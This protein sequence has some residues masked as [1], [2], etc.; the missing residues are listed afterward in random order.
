MPRGRRPYL[1]PNIEFKAKL[2]GPLVEA[3]DKKLVTLSASW[4]DPSRPAYGAQ[5][6]LVELLLKKW[7]AGE[8]EVEL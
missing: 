2:P 7:L 5:S 4:R 6:K 3:I 1:V 8:I